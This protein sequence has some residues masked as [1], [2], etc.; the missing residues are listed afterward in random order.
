MTTASKTT[1]KKTKAEEARDLFNAGKLV[2]LRKFKK[3][4][5]KGWSV[6]GFS[7]AEVKKIEA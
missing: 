5:K 2:E 6:L 1:A 3:Q 7:E 4:V